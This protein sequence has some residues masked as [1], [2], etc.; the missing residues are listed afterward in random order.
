MQTNTSYS[1]NQANQQAH[2]HDPLYAVI[3]DQTEPPRGTHMPYY[4]EIQID[5]MA[6]A[7]VYER[8]LANAGQQPGG[9]EWGCATSKANNETCPMHI[10]KSGH[11]TSSPKGYKRLYHL[12]LKN[13]RLLA[14]TIWG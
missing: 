8:A 10:C 1:V 4:Q 3:D 6:A 2:Q 13:P 7:T 14:L 9:T 11:C 12:A 5:K